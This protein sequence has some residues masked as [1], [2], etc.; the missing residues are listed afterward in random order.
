MVLGQH[1][2]AELKSPLDGDELIKQA[3]GE[4]L[5]NT[6]LTIKAAELE[7]CKKWVTDCEFREYTH[8]L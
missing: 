4:E 1:A 6:F 2:L 3:L 5:V 8:H 7:R